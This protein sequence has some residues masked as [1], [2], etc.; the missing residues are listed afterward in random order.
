M[1]FFEGTSLVICFPLGAKQSLKTR[2]Q[3]SSLRRGSFGPQDAGSIWQ[4]P[5]SVAPRGGLGFLRA[6]DPHACLSAGPAVRR[7]RGEAGALPAGASLWGH[8]L[9]HL[10]CRYHRP[11]IAPSINF[12]VSVFCFRT[13]SF[14]KVVEFLHREERPQDTRE[15]NLG[16]PAIS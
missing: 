11:I 5:R 6:F 9:L 14:K 3:A 1:L 7:Q 4:Q 12:Y 13:F 2:K 10:S 15:W 16:S 8:S